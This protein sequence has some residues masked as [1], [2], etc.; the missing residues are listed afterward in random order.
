MSL[1]E[2]QKNL[3]AIESL[4]ASV[5]DVLAALVIVL[6]PQGRVVL[7]NK[8]CED[9]TGY[10]WAEVDNRLF[11][12]IFLPPEE[13]APVRAVFE[14]IRSGL[15]PNRHTNPWLTKNGERR[16][17]SWSNTAILGA[18]DTVQYVVGTGI[19]IT[20]HRQAE[21][22]LRESEAR[23]R[24]ILETA[25]DAILTIDE[26][27][28]IESINR[29]A[30]QLFGYPASELLGANVRLLIPSPYRERQ[31]ETIA[32]CLAAGDRRITGIDRPAVGRRRDGSV[33]PIELVVGEM[34]L[35]GGHMFT[36]LVR[37]L[38][39]QQRT[40]RRLRELSDELLRVSRLSELGQM[41]SALAHELNQPLAAT[42][43]Y[44]QASRRL[45]QASVEHDAE[46]TDEFMGKA[47]KQVERAASIIRG[48]REFA[49]KSVGQRT[50]E[51]LNSVVKEAS[52]L[53]L[54]GAAEKGVVAAVRLG[55]DLPLVL[56][57]RIQIQ[58]VL[59]N[60]L[61]N[62]VEAMQDS[63]RREIL[64]ETSLVEGD[65]VEVAV[66]DTGCGL[67]G[68]V[69]K[70]LFQPFVTTKSHGIGIGL[71]ISHSIIRAHN[72]R[73][74]ATSGPEGGTTFRFTLPAAPSRSRD[75]KFNGNEHE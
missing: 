33:F 8:A 72:G 42:M 45:L 28:R 74:W 1:P 71:S 51:D 15:I 62:A 48:L 12:E 64:I 32:R 19:D 18:G 55:T 25:A 13:A 56:I 37:D 7:F 16:L 44:V 54:V 24:T 22:A 23:L 10:A 31:S 67:P 47:V 70:R 66:S 59:L 39:E 73:L 35:D 29:A 63:N 34:R 21:Q 11:W 36:I 26:L 65:V 43:N 20:E 2:A 40:E 38:S 53:A 46:K 5:L 49:E 68:T 58:Q 50:A 4:T 3:L 27:D 75:R 6:D 52:G 14:Q 30:E 57:D 17:I 60:L 69:V 41:A 9:L 61:R